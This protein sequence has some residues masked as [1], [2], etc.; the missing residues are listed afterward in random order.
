MQDFHKAADAVIAKMA[1]MPGKTAKIRRPKRVMEMGIDVSPV[2]DRIDRWWADLAAFCHEF[3]SWSIQ[4]QSQRKGHLYF[5]CTGGAGTSLNV[6]MTSG[7]SPGRLDVVLDIK[8]KDGKAKTERFRTTE[9]QSIRDVVYHI[10]KL[11]LDFGR[12]QGTR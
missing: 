11:S 10:D 2:W 9:V 8:H 4:W 3:W 12:S 7:N 1:S 5:T 6:L